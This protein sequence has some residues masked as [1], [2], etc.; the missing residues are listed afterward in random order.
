LALAD[1][2]LQAHYRCGV[3]T[4]QHHLEAPLLQSLELP[5]RRE[6]LLASCISLQPAEQRAARAALLLSQD[7]PHPAHPVTSLS[8][9]VQASPNAAEAFL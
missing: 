2:P 5:K 1:L 8:V 3:V 4:L 6:Q 9:P 7:R